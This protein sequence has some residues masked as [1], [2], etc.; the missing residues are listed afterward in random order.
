MS[1]ETSPIPPA[2][3]PTGSLLHWRWLCCCLS[4]RQ[5]RP[6]PSPA[7]AVPSPESCS[8]C[9]ATE[10]C[11]VASL[12]TELDGWT[13][14]VSSQPPLSPVEWSHQGFSVTTLLTVGAGSFLAVGVCPAHCR[15]LAAPQ[16]SICYTP[17]ALLPPVVTTRNVSRHGQISP[18]GAKS[19]QMR[20]TRLS[21]GSR[22]Q[23]SYVNPGTLRQV[24][25]P[26]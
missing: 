15:G 25:E 8:A 17:L 7:T 2:G 26:L 10:T 23:P 3:S 13:V 24:K 6:P 12:P 19:L 21:C 18:G 11:L 14:R 4:R 5:A 1:G 9:N 22:G 16:A 20:T